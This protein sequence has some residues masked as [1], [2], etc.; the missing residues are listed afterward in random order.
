MEGFKKT[1]FDQDKTK[2]RQEGVKSEEVV[3]SGKRFPKICLLKPFELL[4]LK[5]KPSLR[6]C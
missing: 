2:A 5:T 4:S 6:F 1:H 3:L